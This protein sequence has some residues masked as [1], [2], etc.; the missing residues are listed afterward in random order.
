ML[1]VIGVDCLKQVESLIT[2]VPNVSKTWHKKLKITAVYRVWGYCRKINMKSKRFL[3]NYTLK[4]RLPHKRS[5]VQKKFCW[6]YTIF[7]SCT[8]WHIAPSQYSLKC[9]SWRMDYACLV[10]KIWKVQCI[11]IC[12]SHVKPKEKFIP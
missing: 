8:A 5:A 1:C 9:H 7:L 10:Y 2:M 6:K 11:F 12:E 3:Q 4:G